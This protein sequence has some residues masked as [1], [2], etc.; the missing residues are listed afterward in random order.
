MKFYGWTNDGGPGSV[1]RDEQG[2]TVAWHRDGTWKAD[3]Q[4]A[5]DVEERLWRERK[6]EKEKR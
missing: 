1:K 5:I 6:A 4:K 3:V 2:R